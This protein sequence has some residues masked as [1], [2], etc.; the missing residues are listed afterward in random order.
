MTPPPTWVPFGDLGL[1]LF[2]LFCVF[3]LGFFLDWIEI[4]FIILPLVVPV[5]RAMDIEIDGFG[6]VDE[7]VLVWFT[8]L[9]AVTL[10]TSYLT[11]LVGYALFYLKGVCPPEVQMSHIYRGIIPFVILQMLAVLMVFLW[12]SLVNWLPSVVYK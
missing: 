10:Q 6:V 11:P 1:I 4:T 9:V 8:I 2:V 7:P 5:I 12:P 3:L